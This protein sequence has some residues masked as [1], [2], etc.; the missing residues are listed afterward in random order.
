M[1]GIAGFYNFQH[2]SYEKISNISHK[3]GDAIFHRGPD[4]FGLWIDASNEISFIH[5]RLSILDLSD[6]GSQPMI[7]PSQRYV[8]S[9]NGEI[10][11]HLKLRRKL[12]K[13]FDDIHWFSQCDTETII[14]AIEKWGFHFAIKS[15]SGMFSLAVYDKK[16]KQLLLARDRAGEKPLYF[17]W[18]NNVFIF[19]SELKAIKKHPEFISKIDKNSLNLQMKLGY[20]PAPHCIYH[21]IY[22]LEPGK[23]LTLNTKDSNPKGKEIIEEYWGIDEEVRRAKSTPFE[24]NFSDALC[25]L[26]DLLKTTISSQLISDVPIGAFLSGGIDSS[27]VVSIMQSVSSSPVNTFTIGFSDKKFNEANFAR[28]TAHHLGT[29]HTEHFVTPEEV[30][31][32]IPKLPYIY[33]EPFSDSSQIPTFLVSELAKK[34]VSVSLSGDAGDELFAGY[35]RHIYSKKWGPILNKIPST[36][37]LLMASILNLIKPNQLNFL[38]LNGSRKLNSKLG[39]NNLSNQV[40]KISKALVSEGDLNLYKSFICHWAENSNIV[41]GI[42]SINENIF[43]HQEGLSLSERMMF[44][45]FKNYLP[46]DILAKVDR[47]AMAVSLETRIPFLNEDVI[48]FAWSLPEDMKIYQGQGKYI[49]RKLLEQYL[50]KSLYERPKQGFALPIEDWLRGP[51]IDWAESLLDPRLLNEQGYLNG[52]DIQMKWN[53]HKSG[54]KNHQ[55]ELWDVLMFQAWLEVEEF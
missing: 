17:G 55:T 22:K 2:N 30:L 50:P 13:E 23:I 34:S 25:H 27:L 53:E 52:Q 54:I 42:D 15:F 21:D 4:K 47:A 1:C 36:A 46:G 16:A 24:G 32:I 9:Y 37:K 35:N 45:D 29:N 14:V 5:R 7:S 6:A 48:N 12:E 10:Y 18:L 49:L 38:E 19:A 51:L 26:D 11:N 39:I 40:D 44:N 43:F 8:I 33:D 3:M 20:I 31:D 41:R 28:Q